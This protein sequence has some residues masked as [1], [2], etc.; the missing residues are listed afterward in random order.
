MYNKNERRVKMHRKWHYGDETERREWQDPEAIL[1]SI[2]LKTG[3]F[4]A[5][6]GCGNGYFTIPAA[7]IVGSGG[8]VYGVDSNPEAI[9][10]LRKKVIEHSLNNL[11]LIVAKAEETV[12]CNRCLDIVF[13]GNVLH[14][15]D[16]PTVVIENARKTVRLSGKLV[17]LDWK[18][19]ATPFGPPLSVRFNEEIATNLIE[20]SGFK[21]EKID[22]SGK[23]HYILIASPI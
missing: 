1:Q 20:S 21:I 18:K 9:E 13:F 5:D 3:H 22:E 19:V 11:D 17:N 23:Y 15:F 16:D 8:K 10:E 2:G 7:R 6:I 4:F 12:V 14:D